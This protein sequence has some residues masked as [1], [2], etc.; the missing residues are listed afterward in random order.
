MEVEVLDREIWQ[1]KRYCSAGSEGWRLSIN[2][3]QVG[4]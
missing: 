2:N 3:N 1:S 4:T